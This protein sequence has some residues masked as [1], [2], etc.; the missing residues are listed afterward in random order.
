MFNLGEITSKDSTNKATKELVC[1]IVNKGSCPGLVHH[2][3]FSKNNDRIYFIS[4]GALMSS[5]LKDGMP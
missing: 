3:R 4:G 2:V 1:D 5:D